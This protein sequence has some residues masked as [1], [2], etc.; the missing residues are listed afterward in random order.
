[1]ARMLPILCYHKVGP[2]KEEGRWLNVEPERMRSHIRLFSRRGYTFVQ[3]KSLAL[4][5]PDRAICLTFDDAYESTLTYGVDVMRSMKVTAS[6]YA[7]G[8]RIGDSSTWDGERARPLGSARLLQ[9]AAAQGFEIGNHTNSHARLAGMTWSEQ[10]EELE[11]AHRVLCGLGITAH[12]VAYPFGEFD[13][14]TFLAFDKTGYGVGLGLSRRPA[15][16]SD[17]LSALPRIVVAFGDSNAHLLYKVFL[18]WRLPVG[19]SRPGYID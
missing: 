5:W 17:D 10:L 9:E 14:N 15:K 12:S 2:T 4:H 19:K 7:V 1:M 6:I 18:R 8:S 11:E 16:D 13:S 3:A